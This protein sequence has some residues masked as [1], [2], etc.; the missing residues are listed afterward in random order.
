MF[1][2]RGGPK[3]IDAFPS[4]EW[5]GVLPNF[6]VERF[7]DQD[8]WTNEFYY[9]DQI[10]AGELNYPTPVLVVGSKA[11]FNLSGATLVVPVAKRRSSNS[12]SIPIVSS[13]RTTG[14]IEP[15]LVRLVPKENL[16]VPCIRWA[17]DQERSAVLK[18]LALVTRP[19]TIGIRTESRTVA[20]AIALD[21][22]IDIKP[23]SERL[24]RNWLPH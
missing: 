14:W 15:E 23:F 2:L 21:L 20:Q 4:S 22:L 7:V 3:K 18:N 12:L 9:C 24:V 8:V 19:M 17:S 10:S 16:Y 6:E 1:G 5:V 11:Q 13:R